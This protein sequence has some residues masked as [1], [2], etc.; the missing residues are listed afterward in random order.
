MIEAGHRSGALIT[1]RYAAEQ[2]RDVFVLPG[3]I[4]SPQ[5]AGCHRLIKEGARLVETADEIL[6]E[7]GIK[8]NR[9]SF[10]AVAGG[11]PI[12]SAD[13]HDGSRLTTC[14]DDVDRDAGLSSP[15][16]ELL[17]LLSSVP[18]SVDELVEL[19]GLPVDRLAEV[20]LSLEIKGR[21]QH[22]PGQSY[23]AKN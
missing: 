6:E 2:G 15:E 16:K 22:V 20:L 8:Q 5:S 18:L 19:G 17:K 1:A 21:I 7:Y 9:T 3:S 10:P 14:R 4:F 13:D 11:E 23:V 12:I